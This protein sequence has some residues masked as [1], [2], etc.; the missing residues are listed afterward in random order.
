MLKIKLFSKVIAAIFIT[1]FLFQGCANTGSSR[2]S[3]GDTRVYA[4]SFEDA[5]EKVKQGIS[6]TNLGIEG[7]SEADDGNA[8]TFLVSNKVSR[9][10]DH[11]QQEQGEV[12]IE[13]VSD[14]ET[15]ISVENPEYHF[16]VPEYEK[17]D[18]Q[19]TL[20]QAFDEI[21]TIKKDS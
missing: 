15:R 17:E 11:V 14:S 6:Q 2:T 7:I 1:T 18:Y 10:K 12:R 3:Y 9:N 8:V 16:T 5:R 13:K 21:M 19:R 20:F 4:E